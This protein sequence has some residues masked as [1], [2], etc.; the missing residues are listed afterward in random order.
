MPRFHARPGDN[1]PFT[2]KEEAQ[3]DAEEL[4]WANQP[5]LPPTPDEELD[6]ALAALDPATVTSLP[7]TRAFFIDLLKAMRG[8]AGKKGRVAGRSV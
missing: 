3:R 4:V 6:A 8:Q 2:A 5:P 7:A 1:V